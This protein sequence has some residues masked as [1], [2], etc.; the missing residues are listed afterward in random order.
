MLEHIDANNHISFFVL[1]ASNLALCI[2]SNIACYVY[3]H[4]HMRLDKLDD[5][6]EKL[7]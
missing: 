3:G 7:C 6:L 1:Q 4:R 5:L 2:I